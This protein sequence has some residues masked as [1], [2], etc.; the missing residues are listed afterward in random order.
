ML[1]SS[2]CMLEI[3]LLLAMMKVHEMSIG[4]SWLKLSWSY[5]WLCILENKTNKFVA[6]VT[7]VKAIRVGV[8][9]I[10]IKMGPSLNE[11]LNPKFHWLRQIATTLCKFHW[12]FWI[13]L[14]AIPKAKKLICESIAQILKPVSRTKSFLALVMAFNLLLSN[15]TTIAKAKKP[16]CQLN[17]RGYFFQF[18]TKSWELEPRMKEAKFFYQWLGVTGNEPNP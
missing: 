18:A 2:G 1:W 13:F 8:G 15:L 10:K 9:F 12:Q 16:L 6:L 3:C 4:R 7:P 14:D 17:L 5:L 11:L